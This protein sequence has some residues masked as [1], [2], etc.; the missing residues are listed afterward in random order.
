[1]AADARNGSIKIQIVDEADED[2]LGWNTQKG[3]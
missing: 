2:V 3:V 1:L